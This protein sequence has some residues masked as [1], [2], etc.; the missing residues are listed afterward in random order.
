M[1]EK[2]EGTK[3]LILLHRSSSNL[4]YKT[5]QN[6]THRCSSKTGYTLPTSYS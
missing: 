5:S 4:R 3:C 1:K 6:I 2:K